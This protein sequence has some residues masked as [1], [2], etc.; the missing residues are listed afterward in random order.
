MSRRPSSG[1]RFPTWRTARRNSRTDSDRHSALSS[2]RWYAGGVT[3]AVLRAM[4]T[5]SRALP[6]LLTALVV[7]MLILT[8]A[9]V[10]TAAVPALQQIGAAVERVSGGY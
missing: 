10:W 2:A 3:A 6:L 1:R 8:L 4:L 7:V 9:V 5:R